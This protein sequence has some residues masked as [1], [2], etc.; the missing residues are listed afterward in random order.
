MMH[1]IRKGLSN[2]DH[3]KALVERDKINTLRLDEEDFEKMP[4]EFRVLFQKVETEHESFI[5]DI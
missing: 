1:E 3:L 5:E 4:K 2:E